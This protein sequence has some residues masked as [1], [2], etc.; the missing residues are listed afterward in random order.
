MHNVIRIKSNQTDTE[1]IIP[2]WWHMDVRHTTPPRVSHHLSPAIEGLGFVMPRGFVNK[3][4]D[5]FTRASNS[6]GDHTY[7][8][9][10]DHFIFLEQLGKGSFGEVWRVCLRDDDESENIPHTNRK[11]TT[12]PVLTPRKSFLVPKAFGGEEGKVFALKLV[13]YCDE[14]LPEAELFRHYTHPRVVPFLGVFSGYQVLETRKKKNE[15]CYSLC[16]LMELAD[17]SLETVI[18]RYHAADKWMPS[19]FISR[20]MLDTARAMEY[21]HYPSSLKPYVL[22]RDLKP[23]NILIKKT[24]L[25]SRAQIT[26][27]GVARVCDS[28][29]DNMTMGPGTEGYIA[30]E[31]KSQTYDRPADVWSFGVVCCRMMGVAKWRDLGMGIVPDIDAFLSGTKGMKK[32]A[33]MCVNPDPLFRPTFIDIVRAIYDDI[34]RTSYCEMTSPDNNDLELINNDDRHMNQNIGRPSKSSG[35]TTASSNSAK[36]STHAMAKRPKAKK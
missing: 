23:A 15:K 10:D 1:N 27:F 18:D 8:N 4:D 17:E 36:K 24:A 22:H 33:L 19:D 20:V 31:Q 13:T 16:F 11:K 6:N 26:D 5:L 3:L 25:A 12:P 7:L 9:L 29:D 14:N 2:I 30:P 32:L 21:L 28:I 35:R 34:I